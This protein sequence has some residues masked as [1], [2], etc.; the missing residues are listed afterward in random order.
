MNGFML[1]FVQQ[2]TD[3]C[4]FKLLYWVGK[5][6]CDPHFSLLS[7][8]YE[9]S[10]KQKKNG[11]AV[12]DTKGYIKILQEAI[13]SS[14]QTLHKNSKMKNKCKTKEILDVVFINYERS[15]R[16]S[17]FT[18]LVASNFTSFHHFKVNHTSNMLI[19]KL[20]SDNNKSCEFPI[21][22]RDET[23]STSIKLAWSGSQLKEGQFAAHLRKKQQNYQKKIA[24]KENNEN[25]QGNK[26]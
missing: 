14:N 22:L 9:N 8:Y 24:Q 15:E 23:R 10:T 1:F 16:R 6:I 17:N 25:K 3:W 2:E 5:C 19:A 21:E 4:W 18:Q 20:T 12:Y 26:S 7:R 11:E 13:L